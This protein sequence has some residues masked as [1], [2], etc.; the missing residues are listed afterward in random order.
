MG[1]KSGVM[2]LNEGNRI[3]PF[4][5]IKAREVIYTV[6]LTS[7]MAAFLTQGLSRVTNIGPRDPLWMPMT[8][9]LTFLPASGWLLW[10][11]RQVETDFSAFFGKLPRRLSW[12]GL[13][14]LTIVTLIASLGCFLAFAY[15]CYRWW[16]DSISGLIQRMI[17]QRHGMRPQRSV[18][19]EV[20]RVL[21]VITVIIGAPLC[22]E[23]LFRGILLQRWATKWNFAIGLLLTSALFGI[24]HLNFIGAGLLGL[25]AGVLYHQTKTLWAP[26]ALHAINN[27]IASL[28]MVLPERST[29]LSS[30]DQIMQMQQTFANGWIGFV[31][32]AVSLP[33]VI[34]FLVQNFPRRGTPIPYFANRW[35]A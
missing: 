32:L 1:F 25:I 18:M 3:N 26:I 11:L 9:G 15:L 7:V 23:F 34:R 8:Y 13:V 6:V 2:P 27:T 28:G 4:N 10:R 17:D 24:L 5:R 16:P 33:W 12:G 20:S 21:S 35:K 14:G 29:A 30:G 22:E 31:L 19:P